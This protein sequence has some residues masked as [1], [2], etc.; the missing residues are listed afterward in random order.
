MSVIDKIAAAVTPIPDEERRAE[1]TQRARAVAEPGTW[2]SLV[3]DHH[4]G[5]KVA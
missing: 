5:A 1:G 2:L 4:D 3:L